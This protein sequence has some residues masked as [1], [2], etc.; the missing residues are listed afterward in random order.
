MKYLGPLS[1]SLALGS[2][3]QIT[4]TITFALLMNCALQFEFPSSTL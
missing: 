2:Q 1:L 4:L 3:L